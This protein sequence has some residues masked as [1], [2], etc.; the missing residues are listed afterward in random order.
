MLFGTISLYRTDELIQ[1]TLRREFQNC[2][3]ITIAHRLNTIIDY[4]KILVMDCGRVAEF[5]SP[6]TL[7]ADSESL[8]RSMVNSSPLADALH[9]SVKKND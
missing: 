4:D 9:Q 1:L 6:S 5:D 7:L 8:F 3:V 2:T